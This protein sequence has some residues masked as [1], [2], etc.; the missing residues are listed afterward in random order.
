MYDKQFYL[1]KR[2]SVANAIFHKQEA[3]YNNP[4]WQML[5]NKGFAGVQSLRNNQ[6]GLQML[7]T[8]LG[9]VQFFLG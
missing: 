7:H 3:L 5:E 2:K 1:Q 9:G 4:L 8:F 6:V